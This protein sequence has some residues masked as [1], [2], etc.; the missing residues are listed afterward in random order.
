MTSFQATLLED[1]EDAA[2]TLYILILTV[3][4]PGSDASVREFEGSCIIHDG[5]SIVQRG[6]L[7]REGEKS[8]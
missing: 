8:L 5:N 3:V 4:I 1:S 7:H 2:T 6:M